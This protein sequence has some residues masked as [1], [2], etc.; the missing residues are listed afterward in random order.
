MISISAPAFID[1]TRDSE[2]YAL[3]SWLVFIRL[4]AFEGNMNLSS[5]IS[6]H[7]SRLLLHQIYISQTAIKIPITLLFKWSDSLQ[8]Y[9]I[10]I[11]NTIITQS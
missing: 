11:V 8:C 7:D 1:F 6:G 2:N 3:N 10:M 5:I 9:T 4:K